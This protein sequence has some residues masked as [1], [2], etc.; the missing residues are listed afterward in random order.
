MIVF[1]IVVLVLAIGYLVYVSSKPDWSEPIELPPTEEELLQARQDLLR[2]ARGVDLAL[3]R[4]EARRE[5]ERV[6]AAI[7]EE[8]E[9]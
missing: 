1:L 5:S 2:V 8:L 6:K 7:A 9:R 4:Q 3:A